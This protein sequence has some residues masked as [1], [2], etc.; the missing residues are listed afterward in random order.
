MTGSKAIK[1]AQWVTVV[2]KKIIKNDIDFIHQNSGRERKRKKC[3]LLRQI[4]KICTKSL[5]NNKSTIN[6]LH[7]NKFTLE[8]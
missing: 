3:W 8:S 5:N 2:M 7:N 1:N 6:S 4:R